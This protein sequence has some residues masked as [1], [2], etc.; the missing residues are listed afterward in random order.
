MVFLNLMPTIMKEIPDISADFNRY[1][2]L[3]PEFQFPMSKRA[4]GELESLGYDEKGKPL[5]ETEVVRNIAIFQERIRAKVAQLEPNLLWH[6]KRHTVKE[7]CDQVIVGSTDA[8]FRKAPRTDLKAFQEILSAPTEQMVFGRNE[9]F[10]TA[11]SIVI[12]PELISDTL[13]ENLGLQE[14]IAPKGTHQEVKV[15]HRA[16]A[17]PAMKE[18]LESLE[19]LTLPHENDRSKM[20]YFRLFRIGGGQNTGMVLGTQMIGER[21][22]MFMTDLHGAYRRIDHIH[23]GY[24]REIST[25]RGIQSVVRNVD[26]RL[27]SEWQ[28]TKDP[29]KLAEVKGQLLGLVEELKF[30]TNDHKQEMREQIEAAVTMETVYVK[31]EKRRTKL[32]GKVEVTPSQTIVRLNPGATRARINTSHLHVGKR[33]HEIEGIKGYLAKD[34]TRIHSYIEQQS[35]PFK[36]FYDT[37][38]KLHDRFKIYQL[39]QPMSEKDRKKAIDNLGEL[40]RTCAFATTPIM[41]FEPYKTFST[42]MVE[43]IERTIEALRKEEAPEARQEAAAEFTKIY[44]MTKIERFYN[45]LQAVYATYLSG[46][47]MPDRDEL[48]AFIKRVSAMHKELSTKDVASKITTPPLNKV[49]GELYHLT[50]SVRL[51]AREAIK[52]LDAGAG[53]EEIRPF[54]TQMYDRIKGF[55]FVELM[56]KISGAPE[57]AEA[58]GPTEG[59][60]DTTEGEPEA[61]DAVAAVEQVPGK[62]PES[63]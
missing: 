50:H 14:F 23:D 60:S 46:G 54:I 49:F 47:K 58:T 1:A 20:K 5:P 33:I 51:R 59:E 3:V 35:I 16:Q 40:Q 56:G 53:E 18:I 17:I 21:K 11:R 4:S 36:K 26:V 32:G 15:A 7:G 29:E 57:A 39:D 37:V 52:G 28:Q 63:D 55:D 61:T 24:T 43:Y 13:L 19:A 25:L 22:V 34:Q 31:P 44:L 27:S 2:E 41:M 42:L 6:A 10:A 30:V 48:N 8:E 12:D 62:L 45:D 9:R 38:R